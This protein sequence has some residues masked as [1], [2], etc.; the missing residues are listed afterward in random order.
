M[1]AADTFVSMFLPKQ[2]FLFCV[3]AMTYAVAFTQDGLEGIIVEKY[4]ISDSGDN[5]GIN[6]SGE[7][8]PGSVTYRIYVDLKP[9]YRFQAA[10]GAPG[11]PL[12]IRSTKPFFN[13]IAAG[14]T[15]ANI[16]PEKT[17]GQD[18]SLIDSWLSVGAAGENHLGI[19]KMYDSN[20][21]DERLKLKDGFLDAQHEGIIPLRER[22]GLV[23]S[24]NMPFPTFYQMD[25]CL[26]FL[27]SSTKGDSL[28][29]DNGAW[30]ALGKG[31]V[32]ADSTTTNTVL[33][34]QLTTAGMLSFE[35]NLQ[36]ATPHGNSVRYVA[37]NPQGKEMTHQDLL[38]VETTKSSA[39]DKKRRKSKKKKAVRP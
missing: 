32:G 37:R 2:I 33:I 27:G 18:I 36:I 39:I 1:H 10:Y 16:L 8:E 11:H 30:A 19:P 31:S 26:K 22:D 4:Y 24:S 12:I 5:G 23:R 17:L 20:V 14:T 21:P 7:L 29:V 3:A 34:A 38:F 25:S 9:G 6:K 13:H 15:H 35:L 28:F